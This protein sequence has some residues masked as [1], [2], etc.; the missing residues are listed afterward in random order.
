ML[1]VSNEPLVVVAVWATESEFVHLTR[2]PAVIVSVAG[3]NA[4]SGDLD[5]AG[6]SH[7]NRAAR[8]HQ[9]RERDGSGDERSIAAGWDSGLASGR[10]PPRDR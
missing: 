8:E 3:E 6:R 5:R 7:G 10:G 4:K 1:P 2:S 9:R